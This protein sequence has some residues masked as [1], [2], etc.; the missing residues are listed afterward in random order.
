MRDS[1]ILRREASGELVTHAELSSFTTGLL[2]DMIVTYVS[3]APS[4]S[5]LPRRL[6]DTDLP[7]YAD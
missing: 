5:V 4:S 2:N 1:K 7:M 3:P 6:P